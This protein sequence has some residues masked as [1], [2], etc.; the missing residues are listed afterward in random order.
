M[1]V[2]R[3]VNYLLH[4]YFAGVYRR[5]HLIREGGCP[6]ALALHGSHVMIGL[7]SESI[8]NVFAWKYRSLT[9]YS[10]SSLAGADT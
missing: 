2:V 5:N 9:V 1:L 10:I 6:Y 7:Y 4:Q 8:D 3:Y